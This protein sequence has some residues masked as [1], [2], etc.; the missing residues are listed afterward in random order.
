M[1]GKGDIRPCKN[2]IVVQAEGSDVMMCQTGF[3]MHEQPFIYMRENFKI[4]SHGFFQTN[5]NLTTS[6]AAA[7]PYWAT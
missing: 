6:A 4:Y 1:E 7:T 5:L 3:L 2:S